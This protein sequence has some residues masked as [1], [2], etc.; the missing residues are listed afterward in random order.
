MISLLFAVYGVYKFTG[1]YTCYATKW[2]SS[3]KKACDRFFWI[4]SAIIVA[5]ALGMVITRGATTTTPMY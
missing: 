1:D 4:P 2:N 5:I 3:L